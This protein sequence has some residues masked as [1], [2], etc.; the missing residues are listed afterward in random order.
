MQKKIKLICP[1]CR[2]SFL[3]E[4]YMTPIIKGQKA[5]SNYVLKCIKCGEEM[6]LEWTVN[7]AKVGWK[8]RDSRGVLPIVCIG[9][10]EN[11]M[12]LI[13]KY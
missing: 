11:A 9:H 12:R 10:V 6:Q 8:K 3:F 13:I 2:D 7:S 5:R 1:K 4:I